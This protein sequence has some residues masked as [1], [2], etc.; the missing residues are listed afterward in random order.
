[1]KRSLGREVTVI[2]NK[3]QTAAISSDRK[4]KPHYNPTHRDDICLTNDGERGPASP[5]SPG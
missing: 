3:N 1:M 5:S 4:K 2:P